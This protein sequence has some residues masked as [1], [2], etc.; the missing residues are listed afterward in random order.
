MLPALERALPPAKS[1]PYES[2]GREDERRLDICVVFT[3]PEP[4]MA[5]FTKA[6]ALADSRCARVMLVALQVVPFPLPLDDPPVLLEW[7]Q[8][9]FRSIA[10]QSPVETVVR[11]YLCRD[12]I[13][14]LKG[15]LR[16]GSLVVIGGR[17]SRWPFTAEKRLARQMRRAG[18]AVMVAE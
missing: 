6:A 2:M 12:R 1:I 8:E 16:P 3:S 13:E 15:A 17:K 18:H 14:T 7:N 9:R 10:S 5:A 4:T 11:L